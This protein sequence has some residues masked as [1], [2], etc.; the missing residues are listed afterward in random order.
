MTAAA[1][2]GTCLYCK[3]TEDRPRRAPDG[4]P[5][6]WFNAERTVCSMPDCV[7]QHFADREKASNQGWTAYLAKARNAAGARRARRKKKG[8]KAA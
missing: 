4:D 8:R 2:P 1:R 6:H 3:C 7:R 5:C